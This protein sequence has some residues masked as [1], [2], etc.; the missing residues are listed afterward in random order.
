MAHHDLSKDDVNLA[1]DYLFNHVHRLQGPDPRL[2]SVMGGRGPA[3]PA[4]FTGFDMP[5]RNDWN[6][7]NLVFEKFEKF[8]KFN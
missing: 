2:R 7:S 3:I 1:V 5:A 8:E 4:M 6:L